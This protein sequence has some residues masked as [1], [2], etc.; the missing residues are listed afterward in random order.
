MGGGHRGPRSRQARPPGR[1]VVEEVAPATVSKPPEDPD[2]G[3]PPSP[4]VVEE[5][6][7]ATV[8]KPPEDPDQGRPPGPGGFET[9]ARAPSSTTGRGVPRL[10]QPPGAQSAFLDHREARSDGSDVAARLHDAEAGGDVRAVGV[11]RVGGRVGAGAVEV[12]VR[13]RLVDEDAPEEVLRERDADV[14]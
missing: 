2:Q 13:R 5:V 14:E 11:A 12:R 6:A 4:S 7:L 10:P 8:S 1:S 3:R 9:G